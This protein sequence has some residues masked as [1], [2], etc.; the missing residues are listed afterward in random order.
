MKEFW[1]SCFF[2]P[3][4]P[5]IKATTKA[6]TF[7]TILTDTNGYERTKKSYNF[8]DKLDCLE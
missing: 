1:S 8:L 6:T 4:L 7:T 3:I 2:S 5:N